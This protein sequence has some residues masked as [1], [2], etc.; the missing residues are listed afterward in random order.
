MKV[1]RCAGNEVI[2]IETGQGEQ[3]CQPKNEE[4]N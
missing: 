4:S 1:Y 2:L 3:G